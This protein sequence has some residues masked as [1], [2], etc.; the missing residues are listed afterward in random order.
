MGSEMCIR[1]S[2]ERTGHGIGNEHGGAG[3]LDAE[4]DAEE[5]TG[6]YGR[7]KAHHREMT[8]FQLSGFGHC[9]H[10]REDELFAVK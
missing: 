6:A 10:L 9:Y 3:N 8:G 2:N 4:A 1:D 7:A 5:K